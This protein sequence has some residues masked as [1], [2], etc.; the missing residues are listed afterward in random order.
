MVCSWISLIAGIGP[1]QL[2][3]NFSCR[4]STKSP[5][6]SAT[7]LIQCNNHSLVSAITKGVQLELS[8]MR[9]RQSS[10]HLPLPVGLLN[11][12]GQMSLIQHRN[13]SVGVQPLGIGTPTPRY[14]TSYAEAQSFPLVLFTL[15]PAIGT[16]K[17]NN[18]LLPLFW[19][20]STYKTI[21]V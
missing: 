21:I 8:P 19:P 17:L 13:Y 9:L 10:L 16:C 12:L 14:L 2:I 1:L 20:P 7:V 4:S 18:H 3:S 11:K 6:K 15:S 5:R